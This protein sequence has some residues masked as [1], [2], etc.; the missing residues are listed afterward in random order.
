MVCSFLLNLSNVVDSLRQFVIPCRCA[1]FLSDVNTVSSPLLP[2]S[3]YLLFDKGSM[4][5]VIAH[6]CMRQEFSVTS[7]V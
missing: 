1:K 7:L 6:Q 3:C 4:F 2:L 5:S